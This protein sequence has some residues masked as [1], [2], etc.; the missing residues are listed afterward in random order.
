MEANVTSVQTTR[1]KSSKEKI[2]KL[3]KL[4]WPQLQL[5]GELFADALEFDNINPTADQL[6][7]LI[8]LTAKL[9][10]HMAAVK[11]IL[12]DDTDSLSYAS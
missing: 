3:K 4:P 8:L 5:A 9:L 7:D 10:E 12:Y 6:A 1:A 2:D 11:E